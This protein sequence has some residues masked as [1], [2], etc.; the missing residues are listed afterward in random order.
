MEGSSSSDPQVCLPRPCY[1]LN[2]T[3][4]SFQNAAAPLI[5]LKLS[6]HFIRHFLFRS[7]FSAEDVAIAS[8]VSLAR[9][10]ARLFAR[11][12]RPSWPGSQARVPVSK[13]CIQASGVFS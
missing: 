3:E 8:V 7:F 12:F 13:G 2:I 6:I 10:L 4:L 5:P 1:C 11:E 9:Q